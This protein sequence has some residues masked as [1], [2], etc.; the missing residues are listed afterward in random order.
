ML[1]IA[2]KVY[3]NRDDPE[4]GRV[5]EV[6]KILLATQKLPES[7]RGRQHQRGRGKGPQGGRLGKDQCAY[8]KEHRH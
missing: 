1:E 4:I 3:I 8:Y 6:A 2:Q 5:K 7:G